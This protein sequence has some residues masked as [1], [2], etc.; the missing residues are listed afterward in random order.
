MGVAPLAARLVWRVGPAAGGRRRRPVAG[1]PGA[2]PFWPVRPDPSE[3]WSTGSGRRH[4]MRCQPVGVDPAC[5]GTACVGIRQRRR[6]RRAGGGP[7]S[8]QAGWK[9]RP[10]GGCVASSPT[11]CSGAVATQPA[12]PTWSSRVPRPDPDA[13]AAAR[14][15]PDPAAYSSLLALVTGRVT[16]GGYTAL[17]TGHRAATGRRGASAPP[18]RR[19]A[20]PGRHLAAR[21]RGLLWQTTPLEDG[22]AEFFAALLTDP[23]AAKEIRLFGPRGPPAGTPARPARPPHTRA[24]RRLDLGVVGLDSVIAGIGVVATGATR[25]TPFPSSPRGGSASVGWSSSSALSP[26]CRAA[27]PAPSANSPACTRSQSCSVTSTP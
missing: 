7:A 4:A 10:A 23:R 21:G 1:G 24:E 3:H 8:R 17:L 11:S 6:G 25:S 19:A 13:H 27:S 16:A 5:V 20:R 18:L 26:R 22:G 12:C 9:A 15:R 2:A 14:L